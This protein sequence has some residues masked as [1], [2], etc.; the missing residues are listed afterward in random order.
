MR[1]IRIASFLY[2]LSIIY[3]SE[4]SFAAVW[5]SEL[6]KTQENT[7]IIL[8]FF[9][10]DL[11]LN[12]I[13]AWVTIVWTLALAKIA[14]AKLTSYLEWTYAW[15]ES[16]RE[17]LVWVLSRTVNI[18]I[19]SIWFAITLTVLWID[20][21]I[22]LG[23][24]WFG[25]WF[26]LKIFLT[27]FIAWIL[28]VTQ[29]FYH[30]WDVI[31]VWGRIWTIRKIHALFTAVEQFDWIVYYVPNVKFLEEEVS[32]YH[33]NDKRR[34]DINIWVDYATDIVKAKKVMLQVIEKFPNVLQAPAADVLVEKMWDSSI[35]L[36]LRFW[37]NSK[38]T[39]F[40][41]K[42]NVTETV[43]MAFKQ[44]WITIPFPQVTLS[45]RSDFKVQVEK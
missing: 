17:E 27:N 6:D 31:E 10:T 1:K 28:M 14:T 38:D 23:W 19:L 41:S 20:M 21:W 13:F 42:S 37:I 3:F 44:A 7:N 39:Y 2:L 34:V 25:I 5:A 12:V 40:I 18:S 22:F 16:G 4:F 32:N 11:L 29:W 36:S 43:N 15:E 9:S 45:N 33:S 35:N 8:S 24:L 30:L 26:T